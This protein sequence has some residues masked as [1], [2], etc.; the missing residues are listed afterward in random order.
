MLMGKIV[1]HHYRRYAIYAFL[2]YIIN[3]FIY[4]KAKGGLDINCMG[5]QAITSF[6]IYLLLCI[7][8]S[9]KER[10]FSYI[11]KWFGLIMIPGLLL[12][13]IS[14][15][16]TLPSF[17]IIKTH[18]GGDFYG[19]SCYNYLFYLR[20]ITTGSTGIQRFNGP[21]IEPG[22]LGCI[23]AFIL[24]GAQFQFKKYK[25]L[26]AV[27]AGLIVSF[28]LAGYVLT[29]FG[30]ISIMFISNHI[31]FRRLVVGLS[32]MIG[33]YFIGITYNNGNNYINKSVLSRLQDDN[34]SIENANGRTTI[35]K[36]ES[37]YNMVNDPTILLTGYD[38]KT[39]EEL[40]ETGAGAGFFNQI[41]SIGVIG[42]VG[43]I[44]PNL[45]LVVTS[46]KKKYAWAFFILFILYMYQRCDAFWFS[47][48]IC[49]VYGIVIKEREQTPVNTVNKM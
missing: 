36:M 15:I 3:L 35:Q 10:L 17:G 24:F 25:Y 41:L 29:A 22:D 42:M 12:Y 16:V 48:I 7:A 27:L 45:Y 34:L 14:F 19:E 11:V 20:H 47:I 9:E 49:Y 38:N 1:F 37:F 23:A 31:S 28:S 39:V 21:F 30:Y 18:Y 6:T 4:A 44:L 46:N 8:D 26:W 43:M 2:V 13:A 40:S 5:S 32:I 33:L